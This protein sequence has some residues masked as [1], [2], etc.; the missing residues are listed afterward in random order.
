MDAELSRKYEALTEQ[1][2]GLGSLAVA[3]SGGTDSTLL[4]RVAH[5]AL[6]DGALAITAASETYP[7]AELAAA[8][9]LA[10][11]IGATQLVMETSEIEIPGFKHNPPDRCY[12]CKHELFIKVRQLAAE[13]G[14]DNIAD[15][16]NAD[17]T[18]DYRPGARA[19]AELGVL[20]PLRD[21]GMTKAD[22]RALS[23]EL[24]LPTWNKPAYACLAS[25]FPYGNEITAGK[26]TMVERAEA[27]LHELGFE[28]CRVRHHDDVARIEVEPDQIGKLASP[29]T[30]AIIVARVKE[31]GFQYVA[32]DLEGYRMGSMNE[33]LSS[34]EDG[35]DR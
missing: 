8:K 33:A 2:A 29:E 23:R 10:A 1:I 19:S 28:Q 11:Q 20:A 24:G 6:G 16:S 26:L 35:D 18:N 21:A 17:D 30:A 9:E 5:D 15:G 32:L 4:L 13:H 22:V 14:V 25:R 34:G 27:A 7:S 3:F 31:A 12:H